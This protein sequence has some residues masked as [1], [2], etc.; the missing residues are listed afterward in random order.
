MDNICLE[1]VKY[2]LYLGYSSSDFKSQYSETVS[3]LSFII[4]VFRRIRPSLT[5]IAAKTIF[6]TKFL[7]DLD[8]IALLTY[9]MSKRNSKKLQVLQNNIIRTVYQLPSR[10]NADSYHCSLNTLHYENRRYYFLMIYVQEIERIEPSPSEYP[11]YVYIRDYPL[12]TYESL[13][14][15]RLFLTESSIYN[16]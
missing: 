7:P 5:L 11:L 3:K 15:N 2:Y 8:Y 13:L 1:Q 12:Y 9:S 6:K 10:A 14:L 4:G 16:T